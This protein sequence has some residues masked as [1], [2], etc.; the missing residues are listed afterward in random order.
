LRN[1]AEAAKVETD[2]SQKWY[3]MIA[4]SS[5]LFLGVISGTVV[6]VAL[7]TL[8][9]VLDTNF[10]TVQWVLLAPLLIQTT[11]LLTIGRLGDMIGK[12]RIFV[13]GFLVFTIGSLLCGFSPGVYWLIGFRIV[14]GVGA[15]MSLGLGM[16]L[17]TEA[18]PATER[19]NAIGISGSV[20][21]IGAV[22]GPT[23]GGLLIDAFSWQWIFWFN[24]PIGL[25]GLLLSLRFIPDFAPRG[26]QTF[27]FTGAATLF[28]CLFSLLMALTLGQKAGFIQLLPLSLFTGSALFLALF[29]F[30]E[31]RV[32]QPIIE[33]KLFRN[34]L[35]SIGVVT[36]WQA[37][38]AVSGT[39]VLL[40]FYLETVRGYGPA[41]S[42]LLLAIIPLFIG[43]TAPI[44]GSLS[45]K[46]GTRPIAAT[47]LSI[48][49]LGY[50]GLSLLSIDT[51]MRG[52]AL[53]LVPIGLGLGIFQ[54]PNNSAVMG[55]VPRARLGIASGMLAFTR[56]LGQ[57]TGVAT[58]G[59]VWA[60][61]TFAYQG[62]MPAG[63][64]VT[65]ASASAQVAG[66]QDAFQFLM[67][68]VIVALGLT[69]WGMVQARR[70]GIVSDEYRTDP[71]ID[72]RK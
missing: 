7:P 47:G 56:S 25:V 39:F 21:S 41:Q 70:A 55:S 72:L 1:S 64:D 36:G 63:G 65:T 37:F 23:L 32:Q 48:L 10:A 46:L 19:G 12:K 51:E 68:V 34:S 62:E 53:R 22:L 61:R 49:A 54:S 44:A 8:V 35:F 17:I 31:M 18:F 66:M 38:F 26:R 33:L 58:L 2:Y 43:V 5:S 14:Q 50:L 13:A 9:G 20:V 16:A 27:D 71:A 30:V 28:L 57:I 15:A 6:I 60:A 42:G 3:V 67:M 45:D 40:P 59:A 69:I 24:L 4:V 52:Y 29:L 11:I